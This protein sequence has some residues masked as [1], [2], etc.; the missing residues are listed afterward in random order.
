[1]VH[2]SLVSA[3]IVTLAPATEYRNAST[4]YMHT[5]CYPES[6]LSRVQA[7][8]QHMQDN[9]YEQQEVCNHIDDVPGVS[10]VVG[11]TLLGLLQL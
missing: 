5:P 6:Q 11:V 4:V 7:N 9:H 1:M 3:I 10:E 2:S 8:I